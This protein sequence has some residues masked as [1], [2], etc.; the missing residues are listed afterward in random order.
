MSANQ[1][2]KVGCVIALVF[3]LSPLLHSWAIGLAIALYFLMREDHLFAFTAITA[4]TWF[5]LKSLGLLYTV[6]ID[7]VLIIALWWFFMKRKSVN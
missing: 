4:V 3:F 7:G 2:L 5:V 1:L 6:G